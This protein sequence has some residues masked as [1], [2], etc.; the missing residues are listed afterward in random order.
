M[1]SNRRA[2][3]K[4]MDAKESEIAFQLKILQNRNT[5]ILT[6]YEDILNL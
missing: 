6:G 1:L 4:A 2:Y 3:Q 5:N